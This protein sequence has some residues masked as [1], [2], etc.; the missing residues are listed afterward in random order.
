MRCRGRDSLQRHE[1]ADSLPPGLL[2]NPHLAPSHGYQR[3]STAKRRSKP[4][5]IERYVGLDSPKAPSSTARATLRR[6]SIR[7]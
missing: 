7:R 3:H 1:P 5:L 6:P 4:A 2:Q